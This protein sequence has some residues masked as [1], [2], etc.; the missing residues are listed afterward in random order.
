MM[1]QGDNEELRRSRDR[2]KALEAENTALQR[3]MKDQEIKMTSN[4][5]AAQTARQ[6][7]SQIQQRAAEWEKRA[8]EYQSELGSVQDRLDKEEQT[9]KQFK[10]DYEYMKMQVEERDAEERLAK[11]CSW[12]EHIAVAY[13]DNCMQDRESKLRDQIAA[14]EGQMSRVQ[15]QADLAKKIPAPAYNVVSATPHIHQNGYTRISHTPVRPESRSTVFVDSRVPTPTGQTNDASRPQTPLG[16]SVWQSM[17]APAPHHNEP[18]RLPMTPK[19]MRPLAY[20]RP[21][22]PSP[23]PSNVSAAPTL[24]DD[25][26]YS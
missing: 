11:V 15:A 20:F 19:A 5:R 24:G 3:R 4:E 13:T 2:L 18:I 8:N 12:S 7:M 16:Q 23:T 10:E 25:G 14:L 9:H 1:Q 26:W 6:S 17:H 21:Q 22:I